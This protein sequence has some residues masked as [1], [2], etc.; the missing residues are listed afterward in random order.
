MLSEH[1]MLKAIV[2]EPVIT[3]T[4]LIHGGEALDEQLVSMSNVIVPYGC[5]MQCVR[6][7]T[8]VKYKIR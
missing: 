1:I 6:N 5:L 4:A 3:T 7:I 8:A 2:S